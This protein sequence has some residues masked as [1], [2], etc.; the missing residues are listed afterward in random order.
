M[1]KQLVTKDGRVVVRLPIGYKLKYIDGMKDK[2]LNQSEYLM[3]L[4]DNYEGDNLEVLKQFRH[5]LAKRI[6][7]GINFLYIN[8]LKKIKD[9]IDPVLERL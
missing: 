8:E 3:Y 2:K 7:K 6:K 1:N 5:N 4:L 9:L